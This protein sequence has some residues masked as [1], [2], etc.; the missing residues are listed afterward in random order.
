MVLFQRALERQI[1]HNY[2]TLWMVT[3]SRDLTGTRPVDHLK[4][5]PT[6]LLPALES[7]RWF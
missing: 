1:P 6:H 3:P 7:C 5:N 2:F 4:T